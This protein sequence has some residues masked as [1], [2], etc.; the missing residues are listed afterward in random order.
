MRVVL[1][2]TC[3]AP[4]SVRGT[5][6]GLYIRDGPTDSGIGK[7]F[8]LFQE[9]EDQ[10]IRAMSRPFP[11][12]PALVLEISNDTLQRHVGLIQKVPRRLTGSVPQR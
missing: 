4:V 12:S 7:S 2:C 11:A 10:V 3:A 9:K 6:V 5:A 1:V 8:R